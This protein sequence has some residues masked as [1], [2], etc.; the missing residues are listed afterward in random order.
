VTIE[1]TL[2]EATEVDLL[3][4]D[5]TGRLSEMVVSRRFSAGTHNMPVSLDLPAG[6]YFYNLKTKSGRDIIKRRKY[7]K[8]SY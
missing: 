3:V 1:L 4:Y 5:T 7:V 6:V 8:V 2:P